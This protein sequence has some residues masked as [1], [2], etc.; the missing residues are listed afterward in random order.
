MY[1]HTHTHTHTHKAAPGRFGRDGAILTRVYLEITRKKKTTY[2]IAV[3]GVYME[4]Y[5]NKMRMLYTFLYR[6]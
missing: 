4:R 2:I 6:K 1:T 3:A 5:N